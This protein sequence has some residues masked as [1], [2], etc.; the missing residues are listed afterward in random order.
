MADPV[1]SWQRVKSALGGDA[2]RF[3]TNYLVRGKFDENDN[4]IGFIN[5]RTE[6]EAA[7][8]GTTSTPLSLT[9]A[10]ASSP[11][12]VANKSTVIVGLLTNDLVVATPT[13]AVDGQEIT[14]R[15]K[16][17]EIGGRKPTVHGVE[18][19]AGTPNQTLACKFV[20]YASE[21]TQVSGSSSGAGTVTPP[22]VVVQEND[23]ITSYAKGA[24]VVNSTANTDILNVWQDADGVVQIVA[25]TTG[26][27][28]KTVH[29]AGGTASPRVITKSRLG[30]VRLTGAQTIKI[31]NADLSLTRRHALG[32]LF[33]MP[34]ANLT[35]YAGDIK[36]LQTTQLG[37]TGNPLLTLGVGG[38]TSNSNGALTRLVF[39][40]Q[41]E[42]YTAG[43]SA[44][45][46]DVSEMN[47]GTFGKYLDFY[48]KV[49]PD[50]LNLGDNQWGMVWVMGTDSTVDA[51][52]ALRSQNWS[53][54]GQAN[55]AID[56]IRLAHGLHGRQPK[57]I[58]ISS[59]WKSPNSPVFLTSPAG[60][61]IYPEKL[62]GS[63]AAHP[64]VDFVMS[65][66]T[67]KTVDIA[68]V[69]KL[70]TFPKLDAIAEMISGKNPHAMGLISG[71]DFCLDFGALPSI[72]TVTGSP[73]F[74]P[75]EDGPVCD[76]YHGTLT[77]DKILNI[78][79]RRVA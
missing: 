78:T 1:F 65:A 25:P 68:R 12:S 38:Q 56:N 77:T 10:E 35:G 36:L 15:F 79:N 63:D 73:T 33:R 53:D 29:K 19:P 55:R 75:A 69:I 32:V 20:Y 59:R 28:T 6:L 44:T 8:G 61:G 62:D 48:G 16:Q 50:F 3:I 24:P 13:G 42:G 17:D 14:Y 47:N 58:A 11:F 23:A 7:L 41:R 60:T 64:L 39:F 4:L 40:C 51:A 37:L 45:Q 34:K 57:Q 54:D 18:F 76:V 46:F 27:V 72:C 74:N 49:S 71:N 70:S 31:G 43:V 30:Y 2:Y 67:G 22:V 52:D 21:W 26:I 5:P 66:G 9:F